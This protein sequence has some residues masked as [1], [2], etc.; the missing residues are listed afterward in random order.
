[1]RSGQRTGPV[2]A[3]V[4]IVVVVALIVGIA[5]NSARQLPFSFRK[6][7]QLLGAFG[8]ELFLPL[9]LGLDPLVIPRGDHC[10]CV[11]LRRH[12][13]EFA[14]PKAGFGERRRNGEDKTKGRTKVTEMQRIRRLAKR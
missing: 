3:N 14:L 12:D 13:P 8:H 7:C 1:M 5:S 10:Q 2:V 4:V 6:H 9:P 11:Q